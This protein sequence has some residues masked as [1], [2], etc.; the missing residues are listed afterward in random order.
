MKSYT[1]YL[2]EKTHSD[3]EEHSSGILK[4]TEASQDTSGGLSSRSL[5]RSSRVG[6]SSLLLGDVKETAVGGVEQTNTDGQICT[7]DPELGIAWDKRTNDGTDLDRGPV[8]MEKS[9]GGERKCQASN[10]E[11][12]H[13]TLRDEVGH[14][15][16]NQ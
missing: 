14:T 1:T 11:D 15:G 13:M 6:E 8:E 9:N 16:H 7:H 3:D 12:R 10:T 2:E 4:S 5:V